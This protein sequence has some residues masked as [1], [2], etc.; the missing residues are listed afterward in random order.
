MGIRMCRVRAEMTKLT[1]QDSVTVATALYIVKLAARVQRIADPA[2]ARELA[3]RVADA[4][5][6]PDRRVGAALMPKK[7]GGVSESQA[8]QLAERNAGYRDLAVAEYGTPHLIPKQARALNRKI[9]RLLA[10]AHLVECGVSPQ[11]GAL[12]RIRAAGLGT[13]GDRQLLNVLKGPAK[14]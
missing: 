5:E 10:E 9:R 8:E 1:E 14:K 4:V 3:S 12:R 2:D 7:R 13:I 11:Q 6:R